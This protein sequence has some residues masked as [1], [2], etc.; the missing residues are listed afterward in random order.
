MYNP[1]S[2]HTTYIYS[3]PL[4]INRPTR[5]DFNCRAG[6]PHEEKRDMEAVESGVSSRG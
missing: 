4:V 6:M 2:C 5:P 3:P 1:V